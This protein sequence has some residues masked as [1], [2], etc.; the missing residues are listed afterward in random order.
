MNSSDFKYQITIDPHSQFVKPSK[1]EM[2]RISNNITL[3]TGVTIN[4][5]AS[6]ISYP[7]CFTWFGGSLNGKI[8][9]ENWAAQNVVSLDFDKGLVTVDEV[10]E[11]LR[12]EELMT[13]FWY[14]TLSDSPELR[15]FRI[16][17][18]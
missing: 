12:T 16:V 8:C 14:S 9:G 4:E 15:K 3:S 1:P 7:N 10:I 13:Q 6:L 18:Y 11:R 2:G 5:F 17:F